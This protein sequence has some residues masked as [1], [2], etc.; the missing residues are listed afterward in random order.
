MTRPRLWVVSSLVVSR[1]QTPF[2]H[3]YLAMAKRSQATASSGDSKRKRSNKTAATMSVSNPHDESSA[4]A[5]TPWYSSYTKDDPIYQDYMANEWGLETHGDD[6]LFELVC[7]EGAQAGLS[8][9]TILHKRPNYRRWFHDFQVIQVATMT[10]VE[11]IL[12]APAETA[13]IRHRGKIEAIIH[14]AQCVLQMRQEAEA[15][16]ETTHDV[17]DRFLWSFVN[18]QPIWNGLVW[19]GTLQGMPAT[20]EESTAMSKALKKKG[21]KFVGPTTC[22]ALM[23]SAGMV[24]DHPM[25]C[26]E[27]IQAL[28][29]LRKRDGGFQDRSKTM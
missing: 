23:Q 7:L 10:N 19:N 3:T 17:L 27:G 20:S 9:R 18:H 29:R 28:E 8:W 15:S 13:V 4:S 6:S 2:T 12:A 24:M 1:L 22:Y 21:F 16:G 14:N 11:E 5:L 26:P 25:N